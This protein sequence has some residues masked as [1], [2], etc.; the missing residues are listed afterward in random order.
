MIDNTNEAE[1]SAIPMIHNV[2]YFFEYIPVTRCLLLFHTTPKIK[3]RAPEKNNKNMGM[4]M[5]AQ[6]QLLFLTWVLTIKMR[7]V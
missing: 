3:L 5:I 1:I 7:F 4:F 2:L 6:I